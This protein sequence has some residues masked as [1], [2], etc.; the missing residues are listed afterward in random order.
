MSLLQD[1]YCHV[2]G[3]SL[4]VIFFFPKKC[5]NRKFPIFFKKIFLSHFFPNSTSFAFLFYTL[6]PL[7]IHFPSCLTLSIIFQFVIPVYIFFF[8]Y[9]AVFLYKADSSWEIQLEFFQRILSIFE[10]ISTNLRKP[11]W[12]LLEN[13]FNFWVISKP[14]LRIPLE[15]TTRIL[16]LFKL[17]SVFFFFVIYIYTP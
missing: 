9:K 10:H 11:T 7:S 13:S 2:Y 5:F 3:V 14:I 15:F 6:N 8:L 12:I 16:H 4:K 17:V 1:V